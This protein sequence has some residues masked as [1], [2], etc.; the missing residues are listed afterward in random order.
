MT[1]KEIATIA[2]VSIGTVDR[3]LH[4]RG[5]VSPGTKERIEAI[6]ASSG[7]VPNPIARHLKRSEPYRF[8]VLMPRR[9]EDSGYWELAAQG[10]LGVAAEL[11]AF[12]V[13][14]DILEFDRYDPVSFRTVSDSLLTTGTDAVLLAPVM[15]G[16]ARKF[17]D[18]LEGRIPYAF[19]DADLPGAHPVSS[20][21]Q[22]AFRGGYL[23]GRLASL[24]S[25]AG[26]SSIEASPGGNASVPSRFIVLNAHAEDHHIRLRRDGFLAWAAEHG[27]PAEA[28]EDIDLED[29]RQLA[30]LFGRLF[31]TQDDLAGVFITNA[32]THHIVTVARDVARKIVPQRG[33]LIAIGYDLVPE[34]ERLLREG[35]ID[36]IISQRPEVQA[37]TG[38]LDLYRSI[39]LG[40]QVDKRVEVPLDLYLKENVP[41]SQGVRM[42]AR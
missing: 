35:W 22:D 24:F 3:V 20:T 5:R 15:P 10:I 7:F 21:G 37:R 33:R 32:S 4:G 29:D 41:L 34:N 2:G 18:K 6:V 31:S 28:V 39:V 16:D 42:E 11:Q 8:A 38:L 25:R 23:A 36:A 14:A 40:L 19:F 30:A 1:V 27:F 26:R 13:A 17:I 9:D 12:G